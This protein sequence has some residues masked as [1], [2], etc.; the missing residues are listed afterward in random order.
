MGRRLAAGLLAIL[1][2]GGAALGVPDDLERWIRLDSAHFTIF[3]DASENA[4][5]DVARHLELFRGALARINPTLAI[6]SPLPTSVYVFK[7]DHA[8]R[9]YKKYSGGAPIT[10]DGFFISHADGNYVAVNATPAG[11]PWAIV[12]HEYV[13]YFATN[14]FPDLPTW[15]GEGFADCYSTFAYDGLHAE[16]GAPVEEYAQYLKSGKPMRL[17]DL[18]AVTVASREYNESERRGAFY[19]TAWALVHYLLWGPPNWIADLPPT[20]SRL[21]HGESLAA[22]LK[23][24]SYDDLQEKVVAYVKRGRLVFSRFGI[25]ELTVDDSAAV[26]PMPPAETLTR[27][28]DYLA[29]MEGREAEAEAHYREAER[30]D[31]A[32]AGAQLGLAVLADRAKR[33][34]EADPRFEKALRL[35]PD[36]GV[37]GLRYATSLVRRHFGAGIHRGPVTPEADAALLRA[38]DLLETTV[39]L[40]PDLAEAWAALGA[41]YTHATGDVSKG[42]AALEKARRLLPSR[43]DVAFN[44]LALYARAGDLERARELFDSALSREADPVAVEAARGTLADARIVAAIARVDRGEVEPGLSELEAVRDETRDPD[45]RARLTEQIASI[46][47]VQESNRQVERYNRAVELARKRDYAGART[48][49]KQVASQAADPS[50]VAKAKKFLEDLDRARL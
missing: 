50:L 21:D 35:A 17:V 39:R 33:W 36:D 24:A 48:L 46:R 16:V 37:I 26:R 1:A 41:T 11:N 13:H 30:T 42:I 32:F 19:A 2:S 14:N 23:P 27:L 38:R 6:N 4:T 49:M 22:I 34:G 29:H 28:G 3:S 10:M 20:L 5:R 12:Y 8:F 47:Q 31:P 15:F 7:N 44:L 43:T 45:L 18:L 40:R 25:G 9:P